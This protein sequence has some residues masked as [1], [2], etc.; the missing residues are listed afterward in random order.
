M[1]NDAPSTASLLSWLRDETVWGLSLSS[2][3]LAVA[4]ALG[5]YLGITLLL[6][7]AQRRSRRLAEARAAQGR[8]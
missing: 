6:G 3:A 5:V 1:L 7:V 2:I 8:E 4:S